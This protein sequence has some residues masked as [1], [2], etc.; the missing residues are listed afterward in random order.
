[1]NNDNFLDDLD[2]ENTAAFFFKEAESHLYGYDDKEIDEELAIKFFIKAYEKGS[3]KAS[4]E[5]GNIYK[6][7]EDYK[8]AVHYF[9]EAAKRGEADGY[10]ELAELFSDQD[11][12]DTSEKCWDLYYNMVTS[13][14]P[15]YIKTYL[16]DY[17]L[18][19][20]Q[21]IKHLEKIKHKKN[22]LIEMINEDIAYLDDK[23]EDIRNLIAAKHLQSISYIERNL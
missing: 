12:V 7:E 13:P 4:I 18:K 20:N 8:N 9:K 3:K 19:H 10:A 22:R 15:N 14:T 16:V 17:T 1:M 23:P 2:Y 21:G 5:L 11:D 6:Y